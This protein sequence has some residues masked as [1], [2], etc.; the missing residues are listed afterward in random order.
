MAKEIGLNNI[1]LH[2]K[3][4]RKKMYF[5]DFRSDPESDPDPIPESGSTDLAQGS[6]SKSETLKIKSYIC[7]YQHFPCIKS[8]FLYI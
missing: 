5:F 1:F 4:T 2:K 7:T 6:T 8:V 3:L